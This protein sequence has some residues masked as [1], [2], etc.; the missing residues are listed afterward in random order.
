MPSGMDAKRG[1]AENE[2]A[3]IPIQ[4]N[5]GL[6]GAAMIRAS[7]RRWDVHMGLVFQSNFSKIGLHHTWRK[8]IK[9]PLRM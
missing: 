3:A 4:P 2:S 5:Y 9:M 1:G 7:G 8:I 6:A